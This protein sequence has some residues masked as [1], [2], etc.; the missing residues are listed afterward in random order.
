MRKYMIVLLAAALIAQ[1]A[2]MAAAQGGSTPSPAPSKTPTLTA[3]STLE[4]AGSSAFAPLTQA[5]LQVLTGNVQ[6]PNGLYWFDGKIYTAC[7][8]DG[9]VY[10]INAETGQTAAYIYGIRN[11]QTM[12]VETDANNTLTLWVPDYQT[13]TFNKVTRRAIETVSRGLNGPWG[14]AYLDEEHFLLTNLLS[15]SINLLSRDGDNQELMTGLSAPMGLVHDSETVF[16]ANY[17]STR[18]S[19]EWYPLDDVMNGTA[20]PSVGSHVLVSGLQNTTGLQLGSDGKLY[21]AYALGNRGLVGRVDPKTCMENGGCTNDQV[22]IVLFS[23]LEAPI[24]GLTL[25][26]DMRMYVH[27]MF[28]PNLYWVDI[29]N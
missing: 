1:A 16:V 2:F 10:E 13:N 19:V 3:D 23:D 8:G 28:N 12:Y 4:V 24:A 15:N 17:G 25:T 5:D 18:R 26:P 22:E 9:T 6:K 29:K 11:A 14:L 7:T 20:N 21:F 27:T